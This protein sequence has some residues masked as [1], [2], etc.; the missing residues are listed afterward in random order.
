MMYH[1]FSIL[2]PIPPGVRRSYS[3]MLS[4]MLKSTFEPGGTLVRGGGA[5]VFANLYRFCFKSAEYQ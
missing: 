1:F 2:G 5:F 4:R 3:D